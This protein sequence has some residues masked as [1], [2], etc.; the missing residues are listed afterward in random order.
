VADPNWLRRLVDGHRLGY[1][2]VGGGV[3]NGTPK[4]F[5]GTT[6]YLIEFNEMNPYAKP[7]QVRALPSCNLSVRKHVF[8]RIG[9]FPDFMKG[10]DT[11]FC[12][13]AVASGERILFKPEAIISHLNRT[14]VRHYLKNQVA[15]GEGANE[16]RRRTGRHGAFLIRLPFLLPLIPAYRTWAVGRRL[17]S[18]N[19]GLFLKYLV[20]Y[21]LVFLGLLWYTWGFIRG[22]HR[23]GLST[24]RPRA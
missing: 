6:E 17:W 3:A 14:D 23:A 7:G 8:D 20:H 18:S 15:L 13:R 2:I 16:T 12:E 22:P 21:P 1:A 11:I 4:D 24:E 9:Y 19:K 5:V 10:E